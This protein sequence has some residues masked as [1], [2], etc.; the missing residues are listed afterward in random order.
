MRA[1]VAAAMGRPLR[2]R[3]PA[4]PFQVVRGSSVTCAR[5]RTRR[6]AG[7]Q[8]RLRPRPLVECQTPGQTRHGQRL[9]RRP[10]GQDLQPRLGYVSNVCIE[11]RV[12]AGPQLLR[13]SRRTGPTKLTLHDVPRR[14]GAGSAGRPVQH[15]RRATWRRA[16]VRRWRRPRARR[17][18]ELVVARHHP[19]RVAE[20]AG[21][22]ERDVAVEAVPAGVVGLGEGQA[23]DGRCRRGRPRCR[24]RPCTTWTST[25][26]G[27]RSP[28][29]TKARTLRVRADL[30]GVADAGGLDVVDA[31][32]GPAGLDPLSSTRPARAAP[33]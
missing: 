32:A 18:R 2:R 19:D 3:R 20:R 25:S 13:S 22:V 14:P 9:R 15:G 1:D 11:G 21:A 23:T 12:A 27:A 5:P 16:H 26:S 33:A 4:R 17:R 30:G 6:H 7:R 10:V 28:R 8:P 24:S 29:E 31:D